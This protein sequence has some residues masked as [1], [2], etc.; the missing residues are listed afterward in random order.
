MNDLFC[1]I[2]YHSLNKDGETLCGDRVQC[3]S[4]NED[5]EVIVLADG[6]GSGV[7]ANILSTLT[8]KIISTM[9]AGGM[10]IEDCVATIAATLPVC[11][12]RNVAY[13][14][15]TIIRILGNNE[16][17]IIQYDNPHVIVLRDG[18]YLPLPESSMT[19][20]NKVIYKSRLVLREGD[21]LIAM[22]DGCIHAGVGLELNFGW[23]R[24]NIIDYMEKMYNPDFT[25]KTLATLLLDEC[26]R[27]YGGKPGDDTTVCA[28]KIR[29]RQSVNLMI[30]RQQNDVALFRQE[31]QAYRLRRHDKHARREVFRQRG[32]GEPGIPR[33]RNP[34]D[35]DHRGR[36]FGY[37][38]RHHHQPR[39]DLRRELSGRQQVLC[40]LEL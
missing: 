16:A 7:K 20:E 35:R 33:P 27:L 22:S 12:I 37:G 11:K 21:V 19:I 25:A 26:E 40:R 39:P 17:E 10:S 23:Q 36:G 5:D 30:G 6:L 28:V 4:P 15:F 9:V 3:V 31:R 29:P 2:G 34:A 32:Q 38:G 13:S 14:T 18:K 24:E 1:D 8:S